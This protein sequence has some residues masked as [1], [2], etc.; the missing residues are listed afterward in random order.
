[1]KLTVIRGV[2]GSGKSTL[3][4]KLSQESAKTTIHLESDMF[5]MKNGVYE[6]KQD[7]I[8]DAHRWCQSSALYHLYKGTNVI[9]SNTSINKRAVTPYYEMAL[10]CEAEF[11]LISCKGEFQN[12]H[13]VPD[14]VLESMKNR[15]EDFTLEEYIQWYEVEFIRYAS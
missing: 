9:V 12:V 1:M 7:F 4:K 8:G 11:E 14:H 6:F 15:W 2:P 10:K 5:F 3:A 13:D